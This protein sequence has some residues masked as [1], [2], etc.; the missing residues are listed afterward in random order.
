MLSNDYIKWCLEHGL[1]VRKC[2][3]ILCYEEA[4]ASKDFSD[5]V[6]ENSLGDVDKSLSVIAQNPNL[7][8]TAQLASNSWTNQ[9]FKTRFLLFLLIK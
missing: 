6:T 7:L 1:V 3:Q 8:V 5:F 4:Q 2:Y 9:I